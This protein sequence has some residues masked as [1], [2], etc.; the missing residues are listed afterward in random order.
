MLQLLY[1]KQAEILALYF[2]K[3]KQILAQRTPKP[4]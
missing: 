3:Y 1:D 4:V 2:F